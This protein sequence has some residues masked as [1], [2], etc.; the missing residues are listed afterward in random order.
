MDAHETLI[1]RRRRIVDEHGAWIGYNLDLGAAGHTI[2]PGLVGLA[3]LMIRQITQ[4]V[5]DHAGSLDGLRVLDLGANEGGY[6]IALAQ[7]GALVTCVESRPAH[8]EKARFAIDALGLGDKVTVVEDDVRRVDPRRFDRFDVVLCLGILYHLR[9]PD[10]AAL[11]RNMRDMCR[12]VVIRSA[13]ALRPRTRVQ[14]GERHYHGFT[15]EEQPGVHAGA[16]IDN[17][18]SFFFTRASLLN[19]LAD[20]GFTSVTSVELPHISDADRV[21]GSATLVAHAG[22]RVE[23]RFLPELDRVPYDRIAERRWPEGLTRV[24]HPQQ[25]LVWRARDRVTGEFGRMTFGKRSA[26]LE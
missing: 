18:D 22:E 15:Y 14:I 17:R 20:C 10:A 26:P 2:G 7:H 12:F 19:L 16:S 5:A 25:G 4:V 3:E 8:V 24:A 9:A 23:S 13:V 21:A 1:A 11:C 6:G